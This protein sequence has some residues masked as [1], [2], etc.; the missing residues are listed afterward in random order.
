MNAP[1]STAVV[2]EPGIPRVS[3]GTKEPVLEALFA[4]SGADS[5]LIEPF[6]NSLRYSGLAKF[7]STA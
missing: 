4:V 7:S 2:P 6:P 1:N 5:P 3:K